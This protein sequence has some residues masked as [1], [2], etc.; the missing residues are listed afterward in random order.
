MEGM[1]RC[2]V[3]KRTVERTRVV[4]SEWRKEEKKENKVRREKSR[5]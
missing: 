5:E 3:N 1:G 2:I 4:L